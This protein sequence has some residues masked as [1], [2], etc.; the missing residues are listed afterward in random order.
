MRIVLLE[1]GTLLEEFRDIAP[2][3]MRPMN[4]PYRIRRV[5]ALLPGVVGDRLERV[6][7]RGMQR[8][9]RRAVGTPDLLYLNTA[10]AG[11]VIPALSTAPKATIAHIHELAGALDVHAEAGRHALQ[12]DR[13]IAVSDPVRTEL[14]SRGIERSRIS[15]IH[16]SI[17]TAKWPRTVEDSRTEAR[18]RLGLEP[19]Q[20]VVIG[21]GTIEMRKG[22]DIFVSAGLEAG[23]ADHQARFLWCGR[24]GDQDMAR[25]LLMRVK[26]HPRGGAV[27][28]L[29]ELENPLEVYRAADAFALTSRE[30]PFPLVVLEAAA[31][32]LPIIAW[33]GSG[34][35]VAF[36]EDDAGIT[37][38][39]NTPEAFRDAVTALASDQL[40][41]RSLGARAADKVR[42]RHDS[43]LAAAAIRSEILQVCAVQE[44][45]G[46]QAPR[47]DTNGS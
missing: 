46:L 39:D 47:G 15:V 4:S 27:R 9:L 30:D 11:S 45:D 42:A 10:V 14:I 31:T 21:A 44:I 18:A 17:A 8:R 19:D 40:R 26:K 24:I 3:L 41:R 2:T 6:V 5:G 25:D 38:E 16:A 32:G 12:A 33:R 20:F 37:L 35:I 29:G 36:V 34:G 23:L 43:E 28:F 22:T 1:G 7:R 13:I